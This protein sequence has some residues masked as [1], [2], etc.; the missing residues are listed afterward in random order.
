[1]ITYKRNELI[2][3]TDAIRINQQ[4]ELSLYVKQFFIVGDILL[5]HNQTYFISTLHHLY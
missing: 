2:T 1:M 5:A 3:K 4:N